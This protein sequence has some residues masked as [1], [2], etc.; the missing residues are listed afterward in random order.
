MADLIRT[1][2]TDFVERSR[3]WIR[4]RHVK[5]LLA[6]LWISQPHYMSTTRL[7]LICGTQ[8]EQLAVVIADINE[9]VWP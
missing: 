4:W 1:A 6:K 7:K 9:T 2:G 8:T 3:Q 5:V